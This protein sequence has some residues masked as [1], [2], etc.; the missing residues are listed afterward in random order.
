MNKKT[1]FVI[2]I[3]N[4]LVIFFYTL[5]VVTYLYQFLFHRREK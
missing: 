5:A 4:H 2:P 3:L 1:V